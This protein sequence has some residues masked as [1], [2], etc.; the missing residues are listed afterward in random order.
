MIE[1]TE[2]AAVNSL[3]AGKTV[4]GNQGTIEALPLDKVLPMLG[5]QPSR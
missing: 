1:A 2:E 5:L 4:T 3:L